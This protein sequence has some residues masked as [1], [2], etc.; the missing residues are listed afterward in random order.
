MSRAR[1]VGLNG[2][3]S[4]TSRTRAL[5]VDIVQ[6]IAE[7]SGAV[8]EILDAAALAPELFGTGARDAVGPVARAALD[9]FETADLLV[10]ASPVYKGS[11]SGVFK[12]FIDFVDYKALI[13]R[14]VALIATGGSDRH[15]LVVEHQLRPLFGFFQARTLPTGLFVSDRDQAGGNITDPLL[16]ERLDTLVAEAV[17]ELPALRIA[18]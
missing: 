10:V 17:G 8:H 4:A 11:Y 9:V 2:S 14:P 1:I 13:G 5:L 15:A 18:A 3:L 16:L 7:R 12:H 6:R